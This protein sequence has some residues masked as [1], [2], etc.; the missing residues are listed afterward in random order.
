[1][2]RIM[3]TMAVAAMGMTA[4]MAQSHEVTT[5]DKDGNKAC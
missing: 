5:T 3:M 4:M 1:M 2:K